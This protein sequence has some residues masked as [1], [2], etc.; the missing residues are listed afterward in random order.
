MAN[1]EKLNK[2]F[3]DVFDNISDQEWSDWYNNID[4]QKEMYQKE[5]LLES[6][7]Q[8]AQYDFD[9]L[10]GN[11]ILEQIL[12]SENNFELSELIIKDSYSTV[13][14]QNSGEITYPLAA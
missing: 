11:I 4:A 13:E 14:N 8:A 6:E 1:W 7:I 9:K 12:V 10:E 5:L 3:D 2:E